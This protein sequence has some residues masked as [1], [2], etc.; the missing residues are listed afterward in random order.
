MARLIA[1]APNRG[2][3]EER[4]I[5]L[6]DEVKNSHGSVIV[7]ID[8]LH[9]V[10]GAGGG[11]SALDAANILKPALARGELKVQSALNLCVVRN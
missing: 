11:N 2:E 3:F 10:V 5:N 6:V 9:T 7:F 1:G 8:E 4:L